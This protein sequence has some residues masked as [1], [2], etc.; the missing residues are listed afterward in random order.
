MYIFCLNFGLGTQFDKK[1]GWF[2][3]SVIDFDL[4]LLSKNVLYQMVET[5]DLRLENMY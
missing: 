2:V 1:S 4:Y 5:H 3:I